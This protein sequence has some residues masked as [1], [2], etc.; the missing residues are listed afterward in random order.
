LACTNRVPPALEAFSSHSDWSSAFTEGWI[1]QQIEI[2]EGLWFL[3]ATG[4]WSPAGFAHNFTD[5][6]S[7]N[8]RD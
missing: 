1:F 7:T 3:A 8:Q 5:K 4:S 2:K 6:S